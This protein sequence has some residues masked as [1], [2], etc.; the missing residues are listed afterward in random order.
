MLITFLNPVAVPDEDSTF[1]FL[2]GACGMEH[3]LPVDRA[4]PVALSVTMPGK[5]ID[6]KNTFFSPGSKKIIY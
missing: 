2:Q 4:S 5:W 1:L 3:R 6:K